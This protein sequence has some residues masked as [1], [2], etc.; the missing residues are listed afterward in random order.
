MSYYF[1]KIVGGKRINKISQPYETQPGVQAQFDWSPYTVYI[2]NILT[3]VIVF[4]IILGYSRKRRYVGSLSED[5][6]SVFTSIEEGFG[7][8]EGC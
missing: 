3:K 4:S 8:F 5:Q 7:Y 1:S 6:E 2:N